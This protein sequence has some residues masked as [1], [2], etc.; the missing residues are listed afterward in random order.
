MIGLEEKRAYF[1]LFQS[2]YAINLVFSYPLQFFPIMDNIKKM[3]ISQNMQYCLRIVITFLIAGFAFLI[4]KFSTLLNLTGAFAGV[5]L[6]FCFPVYTYHMY[7]R[8]QV[9]RNT[10]VINACVVIFG[11]LCSIFSIHDS[12]KELI[13]N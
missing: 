2:L 12:I 3:K 7:F 6:Q 11:S 5:A 4:P 13:D 10:K 8:G 1:L 9:S